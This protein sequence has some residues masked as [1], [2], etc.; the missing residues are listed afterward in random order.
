MPVNHTYSELV[1][2][3]LITLAERKGSSRQAI[4]KFVSTK[5]P[6]SDYK[7]FLIRLKRVNPD[8]VSHEKSRYKLTRSFRDKYLKALQNGKSVKAGV[9]KSTATTKKTQKRKP[10]REMKAKKA[11]ASKAGKRKSSTGKKGKKAATKSS[12]MAAKKAGSRTAMAKRGSAK[13]AAGKRAKGS[14]VT[15]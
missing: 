1:H 12:K 8:E 13:A 10:A 4:W 11:A 6:E 3:A 7:Q 5:Y 14:K 2:D 9:K 15:Q